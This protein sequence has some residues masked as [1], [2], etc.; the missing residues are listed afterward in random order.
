MWHVIHPTQVCLVEV[1][2]IM[3]VR[4]L[5]SSSAVTLSFKA[6]PNA[7]SMCTQELS[8]HIYHTE[9]KYR[10]TNVTI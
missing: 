8:L 1:Q 2:Q 6:K 3:P 7:H 10:I 4:K 9:N 5:N